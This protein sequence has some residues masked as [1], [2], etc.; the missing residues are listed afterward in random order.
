MF[1]FLLILF[2]VGYIFVKVGGFIFRMFLGG[3]GAKSSQQQYTSR[4]RAQQKRKTADGISIE[5]EPEDKSK[6]SAKNFRG[7]EYVDYEEIK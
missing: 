7:G 5:F 3:L 2:I 6:R 4:N 1:K